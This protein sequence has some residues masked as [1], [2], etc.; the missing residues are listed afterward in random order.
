MG[1]WAPCCSY[2]DSVGPTTSLADPVGRAVAEDAA[3]ATLEAAWAAGSGPSTPR[4]TTA[5]ACPSS[6]SAGSRPG[7][8]AASTRCYRDETRWR[9]PPV[10]PRGL[11]AGV[12]C[13]DGDDPPED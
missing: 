8:R 3:V 1:W 11:Q 13:R 10:N 4:H 6:A 9:S 12:G 2:S 7:G 5:W